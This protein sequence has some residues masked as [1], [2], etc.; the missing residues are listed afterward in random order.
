MAQDIWAGVNFG[1]SIVNPG[2]VLQTYNPNTGQTTYGSPSA[3]Y[4]SGMAGATNNGVTA[5]SVATPAN[6]PAG[7]PVYQNPALG[8][9]PSGPN[10]NF[11]TDPVTG[12]ITSPYS[13]NPNAF[14]EI[15]T[16]NQVSSADAASL[17]DTA[18]QVEAANKALLE[19]QSKNNIDNIRKSVMDSYDKNPNAIISGPGGAAFIQGLSQLYRGKAAT[20][21]ELQKGGQFGVMGLT[22][23]Q[24]M[25]KFGLL[26]STPGA[27]E[28]PITQIEPSPD[29]K[30][31]QGLIDYQKAMTKVETMLAEAQAQITAAQSNLDTFQNET[32]KGQNAIG[33]ELG[34][35]AT[36]V[37][38][39]QLALKQQRQADEDMLVRR[40][41]IATQEKGFA[42][43]RGQLQM[44]IE[45]ELYKR[46]RD[47][48]AD[49]RQMRKDQQE[50]FAATFDLMLK[51][52]MAKGSIDKP[53]M[54]MITNMSKSFGIPT[55]M[56]I[57][58]LDAAYN[59]KL[60]SNKET[61]LVT[62]GDRQYVLTI[63]KTT[64][65]P[66]SKIDIGAKPSTG[67]GKE[68]EIPGMSASD[69]LQQSINGGATPQEAARTVSD[70]FTNE[71]GI[72]VTSGMLD[73][74]TKI[75]GTLKK[76]SN[77]ATSPETPLDANSIA[78]QRI[79]QIKLLNPKMPDSQLKKLRKDIVKQNTPVKP[80]S[81]IQKFF[82]VSNWGK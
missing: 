26:P 25:K 39:E 21:D 65:K 82:N 1:N 46:K 16:A 40:L 72:N 67:G 78:D 45:S 73:D 53:T 61:Q 24:A 18:S 23:A 11:V 57:N 15:K 34:R 47:I 51:S 44:Q 32:T 68:K 10:T 4:S 54:D 74:W 64:G 42:L 22:V 9:A 77:S 63:D 70:Y 60:N 81:A 6:T 2:S 35:T 29:V 31:D 38:G 62:I 41:G 48:V 7:A 76:T 33:Q 36:L 43:E 55:G 75:A 58:A 19:Q 17:K 12:Q 52:G 8:Y 50:V 27:T 49:A 71:L 28:N 59:D 80:Q 14:P 13:Q 66:I 37:Q 5:P 20:A 56:Y 30:D 3:G 79:E 69:L